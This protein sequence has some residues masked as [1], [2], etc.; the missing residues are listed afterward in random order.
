MQV[1][2]TWMAS[3]GTSCLSLPPLRYERMAAL[4]THMCMIE[5]S[6]RSRAGRG[7]MEESG[8]GRMGRVCIEEG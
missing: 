6:E 4:T 8:L 3:M 2:G 1:A 5:L 7:D